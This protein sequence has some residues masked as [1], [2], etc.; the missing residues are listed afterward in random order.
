MNANAPSG[1]TWRT[2]LACLGAT[3]C[4]ALAG[5]G[6]S[7]DTAGCEERDGGVVAAYSAANPDGGRP[8]SDAVDAAVD[9]LCDRARALDLTADVRR[10]GAAQVEVRVDRDRVRDLDALTAPGQLSFYD[11]EP[12]LFGDPYQPIDGI[13]RAIRTAARAKPRAEET[14]L[15]PG[16]PAADVQ[17]RFGGDARRIRA[18]YDAQNDAVG[19]KYYVL[20]ARGKLVRPPGVANDADAFSTETPTP[21]PGGRSVKV[22][23][24]VLV[25]RAELPPGAAPGTPAQFF[26][27]EDDRELTGA[28]IENP[29]Q[30]FDQQTQE[31]IVTMDFS[32]RGREAF[33]RVT[34]RIAERGQATLPQPGSAPEDRFQRFMIA[35]DAQIVSLATIDFI[36]N[37]EGIDASSGAQIN[38]IGSIEDTKNLADSLRIGPL[39]VRLERVR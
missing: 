18:H 15:P 9:V 35:L 6:E 1:R 23:R 24:G 3:A 29:A 5:C 20:D 13:A 8:A 22:P 36:Q 30:G 2:A 21:P 4:V 33:A 7:D 11:W 14:D 26:V 17:Q 38:G 16:G 25:V 32:D 31:P 28:D 39:P 12:N 37:P 34:K 10:R 27:V 19:D